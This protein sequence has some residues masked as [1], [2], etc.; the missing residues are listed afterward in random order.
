MSRKDVRSLVGTRVSSELAELINELISRSQEIDSLKSIAFKTVRNVATFT[1]QTNT[2]TTGGVIDD[3][4]AIGYNL[5]PAQLAT[6]LLKQTAGECAFRMGIESGYYQG[7]PGSEFTAFEWNTDY[8]NPSGTVQLRPLFYSVNLATDASYLYHSA[9]SYDLFTPA[10][11]NKSID[12]VTT[13]VSCLAGVMTVTRFIA[14]FGSSPLAS[15]GT[16]RAIIFGNSLY[17]QNDTPGYYFDAYSG[18]V[19]NRV[20]FLRADGATKTFLLSIGKDDGSANTDI[21]KVVRNGMTVTRFGLPF[22]LSV[23]ANNAAA[24]AGGL[25][26]GDLYR[27][28]ADPSVVCVV[29]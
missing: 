6:P 15:Y 19:D 10:W 23:Y 1:I 28:G 22:G 16:P 12:A 4:I 25:A 5:G 7:P 20:W 14:G 24:L 13:Y 8:S 29:T 18:A 9:D 27:T 17:H 3:A 11:Y 26:V 21:I 2:V